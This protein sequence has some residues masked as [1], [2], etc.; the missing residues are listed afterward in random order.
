MIL[1][2]VYTS[3]ILHFVSILISWYGDRVTITTR[4]C[5]HVLR[6]RDPLSSIITKQRL[7]VTII[8]AK[9]PIV[10]AITQHFPPP[11]DPIYSG[12]EQILTHNVYVNLNSSRRANKRA[13][14]ELTIYSQIRGTC[15]FSLP[16][17]GPGS[18]PVRQVTGLSQLPRVASETW[19][20]GGALN[21]TSFR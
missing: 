14:A 5:H 20:R 3:S 6:I 1:R 11:R 15:N 13:G 7:G 8:L 10:I 21:T 2:S 12:Q 17:P 9:W 18:A 19:V 4:H 16:R